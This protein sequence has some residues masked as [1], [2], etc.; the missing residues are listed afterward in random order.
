MAATGVFYENLEF[1]DATLLLGSDTVQLERRLVALQSAK[2]P[3]WEGTKHADKPAGWRC[4]KTV[5][6]CLQR[7]PRGCNLDAT[8]HLHAAPSAEGSAKLE[9]TNSAT[10]AACLVEQVPVHR[11][12][13]AAESFYFKTAIS[14][15][16]G[17]S[18]VSQRDGPLYPIIVVHEH[19][20]PTAKGVLEFL[21]TKTLDSKFSTVPKLMRLLLVSE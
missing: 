20:V 10:A 6:K 7:I 15:L 16:V 13:L 1:H 9:A 4:L 19:D 5:L 12:I 18:A 17:Q 2:H 14:T 3:H 21:Y 11:V 8:A